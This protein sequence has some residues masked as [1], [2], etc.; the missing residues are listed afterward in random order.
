MARAMLN[1]KLA[2]LAKLSGVSAKSLWSFE[3]ERSNMTRGNDE[4]VLRA[5][6]RLGVEFM[7]ER[8]GV[9]RRENE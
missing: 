9:M 3:A 8:D 1:V 5:F 4:L 2:D 7:D 6:E